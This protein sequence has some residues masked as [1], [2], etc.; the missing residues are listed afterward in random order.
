MFELAQSH[1]LG[2]DHFQIYL[3]IGRALVARITSFEGLRNIAQKLDRGLDAFN[4]L[5]LKTGLSMELL[6]T[7]FRPPSA[8]SVKQLEARLLIEELAD[9]F[10]CWKWKSSLSIDKL[11]SLQQSLVDFYQSIGPLGL[12]TDSQSDVGFICH[13]PMK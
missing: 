11:G 9:W 2:A 7:V 5:Q 1:D 3:A 4:S 10:D 8:G 13:K 12:T 6:W